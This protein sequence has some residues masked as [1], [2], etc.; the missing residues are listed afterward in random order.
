MIV[1]LKKL[2][3]HRIHSEIYVVNDLEDLKQSIQES[4]LL[5]KIVVNNVNELVS[6]HR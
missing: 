4:G 6:R 2:K 5:E 3:V 1:K